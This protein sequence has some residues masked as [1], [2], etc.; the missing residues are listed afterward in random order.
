MVLF[1]ENCSASRRKRKSGP[2]LQA[3]DFETYVLNLKSTHMLSPKE[4]VNDTASA[5]PVIDSP[6]FKAKMIEQWQMHKENERL[7]ELL[8]CLQATIQSVCE[9][10]VLLDR[11][12]FLKERGV[13]CYVRK[14]TDDRISPRCYALVAT[15]L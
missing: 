7:V 12:V 4:V 14:V 2:N 11:V 5:N 3:N 15:K 9:N 13:D 1:V 10:L 6:R 8:L